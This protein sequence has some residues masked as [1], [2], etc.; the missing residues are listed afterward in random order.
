MQNCGKPQENSYVS[1][2]LQLLTYYGKKEE[3]RKF[4]VETTLPNNLTVEDL[5]VKSV[6]PK[7]YEVKIFPREIHH[8]DFNWEN[9][10]PSNLILLCNECHVK[11]G[12]KT[13][14]KRSRKKP[15]EERRMRRE[16]KQAVKW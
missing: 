4:T 10:S 13:T 8:K 2:E 7:P 9:D 3:E 16:K 14:A 5:K 6:E 15:K 1:R 11:M 12:K